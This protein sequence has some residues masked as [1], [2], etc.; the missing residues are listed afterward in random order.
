MYL[1]RPR[2][3]FKP[4]VVVVV[5]VVVVI[6]IVIVVDSAPVPSPVSTPFDARVV[7]RVASPRRAYFAPDPDPDAAAARAARAAFMRAT[8]ANATSILVAS[9]GP[10]ARGSGVACDRSNDRRPRTAV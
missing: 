3:L 1:S 5:V 6:V 8:S 9:L 2:V 7:E 4:T 10:V